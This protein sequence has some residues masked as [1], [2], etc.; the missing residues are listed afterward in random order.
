VT[1][2][3]GPERDLLSEWFAARERE[4]AA[5]D[6]SRE[7]LSRPLPVPLLPPPAPQRGEAVVRLRCGR[8]NRVLGEV[9]GTAADGIRQMSGH[10]DGSESR[11]HTRFQRRAGKA[12][13]SSSLRERLRSAAARVRYRCKD[14]RCPGDYPVRRDKLDA[15]F[16]R[17]VT[18]SALRRDRVIVLP[19][20][21]R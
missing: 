13:S 14:R 15:A 1:T 8:C 9:W 3:I 12:V 2:G 16:R 21:L 17:V 7:R 6:A 19:V 18:A 4:Q 11:P 20:D 10:E 5:F